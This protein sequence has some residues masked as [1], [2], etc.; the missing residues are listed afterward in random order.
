MAQ[1]LAEFELLVL[2]A[3]L[4]LGAEEAYTVWNRGLH[5]ATNRTVGQAGECLYDAAAPRGQASRGDAA[6]RAAARARWQS[7][8]GGSRC[9]RLALAAVRATTGAIRAMVGEL[10]G[11]IGEAG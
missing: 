8:G 3:A 11:I 2:L 7:R 4:H 5:P 10:D 9:V 6:W 1:S